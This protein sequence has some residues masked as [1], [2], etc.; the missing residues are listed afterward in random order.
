MVFVS[1]AAARGHA[2][3]LA[4][5]ARALGE[6]KGSNDDVAPRRQNRHPPG[7]KKAPA[8]PGLF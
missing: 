3:R 1:F 4:R 2:A 7:Y 6:G 8:M 5:L